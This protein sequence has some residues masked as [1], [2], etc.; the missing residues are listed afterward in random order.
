MIPQ[1]GY[2]VQDPPPEIRHCLSVKIKLCHACVIYNSAPRS[3]CLYERTG[4]DPT[5][6]AIAL[7]WYGDVDNGPR[8][9]TQHTVGS[10]VVPVEEIGQTSILKLSVYAARPTC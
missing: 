1:R 5:V 2:V 7:L 4:E 6:Y 10:M 3:K 8:G 9:G